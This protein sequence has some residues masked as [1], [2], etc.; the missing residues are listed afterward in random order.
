MIVGMRGAAYGAALVALAGL[1]PAGPQAPA[2]D[3]SA[4]RD[5]PPAMGALCG[6]ALLAVAAEVGRRCVADPDPAVQAELDSAVARLD[7]F[8]LADPGWDRAALDRLKREQAGL[9]EPVAQFCA[10]DAVMI[11]RGFAGA[12][13]GE[14]ER[15][16]ETLASSPRPPHWG[17]CL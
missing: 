7:A 8:V 3:A 9:G 15:W 11:Y 16:A 14:L 17:D 10:A 13:R 6:L 1:A 12:R 2:P 4:E 5:R